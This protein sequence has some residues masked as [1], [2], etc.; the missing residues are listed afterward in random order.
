MNAEIQRTSLSIVI[1]R[2]SGRPINHRSFGITWT[3]IT[4]CPASAGHD[5]GEET[6]TSL[7]ADPARANDLAPLRRLLSVVGGKLI[8]QSGDDND[9][10]ARQ[11][12]ARFGRLER[13]DERRADL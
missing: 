6:P 10:L 7:H 3:A 8:R 9:A 5:E 13:G 4:G 1:A 12:L 11:W 2:E